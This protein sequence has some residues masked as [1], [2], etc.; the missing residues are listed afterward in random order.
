MKAALI[1]CS[2]AVFF[3]IGFYFSWSSNEFPLEVATFDLPKASRDPAAIKKVYDFSHLEGSALVF[4]TK[5]RLLEGAKIIPGNQDIEV[6]LGHFV[7]RGTDGQKEFACQRFSKV[8]MNFEGE[9]LAIGGELPQMEVEGVCEISKDINTMAAIWIPT[10]RILGET[11]ADGEFDYREGHPTKLKFANVSEQWPK[12]WRLKS[13]Q[14]VDPSGEYA[15]LTIQD[16]ELKEIL[17]KPFLV[18]F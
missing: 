13:V 4:A 1:C 11:V 10:S 2:L 5:Q 6:D 8:I 14:L 17:K 15:D 3:A 9:G 12:L 16:Q 7:L 18:K